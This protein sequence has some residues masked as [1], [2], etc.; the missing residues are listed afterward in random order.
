M[1]R[2]FN[3]F[4]FFTDKKG[5][6]YQTRE[7]KLGTSNYIVRPVHTNDIKDLISI[8]REIYKEDIPWTRSAFLSELY[9]TAPH[10]YL[11]VQKEEKTIGFIGCRISKKDAHIT[12]VAISI[13]HQGKGIGSF[14]VREMI[15]FAQNN[16]CDTVSLE[17][18]IS[19][20]K[21]QSVYRKAGF[22]STSIKKN[23]YDNDFEDALEMIFQLKEG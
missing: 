6:T 7:V 2:K 22:V 10:R 5:K 14:L 9:T 13:D 16:K 15:F 1:L 11:L 19:N 18:R 3:F 12:N 20:K 4:R 23:Y 8:E 17:V 21:A